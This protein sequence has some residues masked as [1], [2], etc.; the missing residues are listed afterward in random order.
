M[1]GVFA[2]ALRAA[3]TETL[4][5]RSRRFV[6]SLLG[7]SRRDHWPLGVAI[8]RIVLD[9]AGV[10]TSFEYDQPQLR[11]GG[12][13]PPEDGFCCTDGEFALPARFFQWLI[14]PLTLLVH[15]E[16]RFRLRYPLAPPHANAA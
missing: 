11:E 12:C 15:I 16:P 10:T 1:D 9:H 8:R 14:G 4:L 3:P 6:P 7:L 2:F 13:Y 5:L